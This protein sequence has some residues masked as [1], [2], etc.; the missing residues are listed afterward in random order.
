MRYFIYSFALIFLAASPAMAEFASFEKASAQLQSATVTVRVIPA[1]PMAEDAPDAVQGEAPVRQVE[2]CSGASLG[3]GLV[4]TYADIATNDEVRITIPGGDQARAK[5][6][7][8]DHVS[9][10]TL[11][12]IDQEDV[13]GFQTAEKLPAVGGWVL[14]GAGWAW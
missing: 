1:A 13:P 7:V 3:K 6:R 8:L 11:L 2:I 5:L 14:A 4:V 12:E 10:L 9:G